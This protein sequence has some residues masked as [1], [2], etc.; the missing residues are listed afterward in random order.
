M[1]SLGREQ[2]QI[3][4]LQV[5][6]QTRRHEPPLDI[7]PGGCSYRVP[8]CRVV[9]HSIDMAP[10]SAVGSPDGTRRPSSIWRYVHDTFRRE[11]VPAEDRETDGKPKVAR[12]LHQVDLPRRELYKGVSRAVHPEFR[13][14]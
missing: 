13:I 3:Q 7:R 12:R 14:V 2:L 10:A 8:A 11:V 4:I 5:A 9:Q 1:V 6:D